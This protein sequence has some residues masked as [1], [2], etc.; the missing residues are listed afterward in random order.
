MLASIA[1]AA[2]P[3]IE[4]QERF[5][6][7]AKERVSRDLGLL[8]REG[9]VWDLAGD[10]HR[11]AGE[12]SMVNQPE[13][14]RVAAEGEKAAQLLGS[15]S[16]QQA[17]VTCGRVLRRLGYLLQEVSSKRTGVASADASRTAGGN[18]RVLVVD[19]SPVAAHAL[20]DVFEVRGFEVR[21]AMSLDEALAVCAA[22]SPAVLVADVYMPNLDV[23]VLCQ[24]F[25]E[26]TR[27]QRTAILL[28]SGRSEG[29]LRD[30]LD[31][32]RPEAFVSKLAGADVVV[33]R[34]ATL[35]QGLAQ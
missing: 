16:D 9:E 2:I 15:K 35:F 13:V 28:I 6:S 7:T 29:E 5:I 25:R 19:D 4:L 17:R 8:G 32:I 26:V 18:R 11:L 30:R 21:S 1:M 33:S 10:L 34:V 20:S 24:R 14:A 27:G 22:F 31:A 3:S 23:A 12:A